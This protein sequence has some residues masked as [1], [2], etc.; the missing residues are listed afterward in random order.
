MKSFVELI[1]KLK[2][3]RIAKASDVKGGGM[4]YKKQI[5]CFR[6]EMKVQKQ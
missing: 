4:N 5:P 1:K 2:E 3:N 6:Y